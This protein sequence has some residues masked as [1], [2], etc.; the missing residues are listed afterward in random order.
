MNTYI[1]FV[2]LITLTLV[3]WPPLLLIVT[4]LTP[5]QLLDKYLKAPYFNSGEVIAFNSFPSFI[6]RTGLFCRLYLTPKAVK[7]RGLHGFVEDSPTWYKIS[8]IAVIVGAIVHLLLMFIFIA[9]LFYM[10]N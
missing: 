3:V 1:N 10:D 6:V 9:I 5:K 4:L 8:V 7:G 2:G